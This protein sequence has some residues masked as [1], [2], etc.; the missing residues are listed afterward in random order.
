MSA[1]EYTITY[2]EMETRPAVRIPLP[3]TAVPVEVGA[4]HFLRLYAAV[5][6]DYQWLDWFEHPPEA[7]LAK[8]S[9]ADRPIYVLMQ[10]DVEQGFCVLDFT[11]PTGADLAYFGMLPHAVSKGLGKP[12]LSWAIHSLWDRATQ[13]RV[14]INTCTLDHP[15]ALPLYQKMGFVP[16][17]T[18]LRQ[19]KSA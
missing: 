7:A 19:R 6:A 11:D 1:V 3:T 13:P 9:H 17:S 4:E 12:F 2:L 5:G 18:E 10:D 8:Y 14:T 16:I 15:A